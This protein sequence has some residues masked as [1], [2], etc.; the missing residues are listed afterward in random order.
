[1]HNW[2]PSRTFPTEV[3]EYHAVLDPRSACPSMRRYWNG[4]HWS[5]SYSTRWPQHLQDKCKKEYCEFQPAWLSKE[6]TENLRIPNSP[7]Y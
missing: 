5:N 7:W 4:K 2:N 6:D 1:M 3:G